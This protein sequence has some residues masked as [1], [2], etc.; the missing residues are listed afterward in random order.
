VRLKKLQQLRRAEMRKRHWRAKAGPVELR[1]A[2]KIGQVIEGLLY[3]HQRSWRIEMS[4]VYP[5]LSS[6]NCLQVLAVE[7]RQIQTS[8]REPARLLMTR[9]PWACYHLFV[10]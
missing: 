9:F 8:A 10:V 1:Q 6:Q 4:E 2:E 3:S 7:S 5:P